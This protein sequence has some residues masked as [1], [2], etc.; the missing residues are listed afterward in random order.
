MKK[1]ILFLST[2]LIVGASVFMVGCKK[3]D[4]TAPVVTINGSDM[5]IYL[6]DSYV[7]LGATANDD[8]DGV[9]T[10]VASGSVNTNLVGTYTIT[11]TATDAAG[12]EGT[13][14][15]TITVKNGQEAMEGKYDGSE[16]DAVGPY[17]YSGNTDPAKT[18]TVTI[19]TTVKNRVFMTRLG[20][21]ANNTVYLN[22]TGNNI[23]MP[24]QTVSNVGTGTATCDVHNRKSGGTG[25]KT[26]APVGFTLS[27]HDEKVAPC[28]GTRATVNA[29]FIKK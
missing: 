23:D 10:A 15:R 11:Y 5:T 20:D 19:S 7:E 1:N 2:A 22:V 6:Q 13:A 29:T 18:V 12:N 4:T 3:D 28:S 24:E 17:T 14:A 25:V 8:E 26:T 9:I 27:Y 16:V 21:F